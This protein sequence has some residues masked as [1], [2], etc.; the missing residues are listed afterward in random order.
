MLPC[1]P[2]LTIGGVPSDGSFSTAG[3]PQGRHSFPEAAAPTGNDLLA[4][5]YVFQR[6]RS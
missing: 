5:I 1:E 2:G 4:R 6:P 3:L